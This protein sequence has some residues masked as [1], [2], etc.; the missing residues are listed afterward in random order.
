MQREVLIKTEALETLLHL[1]KS[2]HP[3]EMVALLRGEAK[4]EIRIEEVLLAPLALGG[5]DFSEFPLD[6][7]PIDPS[8]IGT[9]HSHP[10]HELEPSEEDLN[11]SYGHVSLIVAYP[12]SGARD[13]AA[14]SSSSER[15]KLRVV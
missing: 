6:A 7:L 1:A 11:E 4:K 10:V 8:I 14:Y 3:K 2:M 5:E 15:L 12:Y 13:V 9:A